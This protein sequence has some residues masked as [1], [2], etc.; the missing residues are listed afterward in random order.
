VV[1]TFAVPKL[2]IGRSVLNCT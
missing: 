2:H 1:K